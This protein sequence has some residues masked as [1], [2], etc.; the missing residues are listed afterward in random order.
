MKTQVIY[1]T[2]R[3][4]AFGVLSGMLLSCASSYWLDDARTLDRGNWRVDGQIMRQVIIQEDSEDALSGYI[5]LMP[6]GNLQLSYGL[7]NRMDVG[8]IFN[9]FTL[10]GASWKY[11]LTRSNTGHILSIGGRMA[12][13]SLL[14]YDEVGIY[15]GWRIGSA[16]DGHLWYTRAFSRTAYTIQPSIGMYY[17]YGQTDDKYKIIRNSYKIGYASMGLSLTSALDDNVDF[18]VGLQHSYLFDL[19]DKTRSFYT[20]N[21]TWGVSYYIR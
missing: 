6:K 15:D 7:T 14:E 16:V 2:M 8:V 9:Q 10:T 4:L 19:E 5:W 20:L 13:K 18:R 12:L 3:H 11:R 1:A 21:I 17:L